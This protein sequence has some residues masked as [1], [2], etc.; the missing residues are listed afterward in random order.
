MAH[1]SK[2][3]PEQA[4]AHTSYERGSLET[5]RPNGHSCA[6]RSLLARWE[7][8]AHSDLLGGRGHNDLWQR[9][10]ESSAGLGRTEVS[11]SRS[12]DVFERS[13]SIH[14]ARVNQARVIGRSSTREV[15]AIDHASC[16]PP[17]A[18][19]SV[20]LR[21][22]GEGEA[23]RPLG[24]PLKRHKDD[25]ALRDAGGHGNPVG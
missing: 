4:A 8:P 15:D 18:H 6:R 9:Q 21:R 14:G 20:T 7:R 25:R 13:G 11:P 17:Q 2:S 19:C 10:S 22:A 5:Y 23:G 16:P 24:S 3:R 1:C 12:L